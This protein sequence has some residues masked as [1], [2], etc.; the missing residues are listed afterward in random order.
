MPSS[1]KIIEIISSLQA[2]LNCRICFHDRSDLATLPRE[3]STHCNSV[4]IEVK[5]YHEKDCMDFD[6]VSVHQELR[7]CPEGR[8]H[9]CPF[10]IK[11]I[12]VP[13]ICYGLQRGVL[14]AGGGGFQETEVS[15]LKNSHNIMRCAA[16]A[17]GRL[18]EEPSV[19][20]DERARIIM[21]F[22][23]D[24]FPLKVVTI[25]DLAVELNLSSSRTGKILKKKFGKTFR[26][27]L[28]EARMNHAAAL[29]K[30][31]ALK[32]ADISEACG[33]SDPNYFSIVFSS[34]F[35][36]S[37]TEFRHRHSTGA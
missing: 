6:S 37:P 27:M 26:E 35:S 13:V 15:Q 10:G 20:G 18:L 17:I 23:Q 8:I 5:K 21:R 11:E 7:E 12:A 22:F 29:L 33:Y 16:A 31:S 3:L 1:E 4:C 19:E 9:D 36:L 28:T 32:I 25:G 2:V 14:F 30:T 24:A 34:A